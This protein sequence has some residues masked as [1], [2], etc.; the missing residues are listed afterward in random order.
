MKNEIK[1]SSKYISVHKKLLHISGGVIFSLA[2]CTKV[3]VLATVCFNPGRTLLI[4]Y[5]GY[6]V[7]C[8]EC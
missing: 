5:R 7:I 3:I 8:K 1:N 4:D 6:H 2:Q